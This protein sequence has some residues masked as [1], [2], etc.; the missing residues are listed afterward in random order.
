MS[1]YE[2]ME[3]LGMAI[4]T[5]DNLLSA[6]SVPLPD[7]LHMQGLRAELPKLRDSLRK[8]LHRRDRRQPLGGPPMT[9]Q[10]ADLARRCC[11]GSEP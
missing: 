1:T 2:S 4:D 6:M 7:H 10:P 8:G 5:L 3:V 9:S 11:S